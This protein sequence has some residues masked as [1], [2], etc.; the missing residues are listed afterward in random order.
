VGFEGP[1]RYRPA[2][3]DISRFDCGSEAQTR[4]LRNVVRTAQ[5]ARTA[6][7]YVVTRTGENRVVGY[8]ALAAA[9]VAQDDSPARLKKAAG[10]GPIPVILLARLGLDVTVQGTGVGAA[11]VKDAMFRARQSADTIGARALVIHAESETARSFYLHL[12]EFDES[13]SDPF[14]LTC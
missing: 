8:Y 6:V 5:A 7:A 10:Q 4:W 2:R 13:P 3:D 11:M 14:H 9:G 12:A 1:R